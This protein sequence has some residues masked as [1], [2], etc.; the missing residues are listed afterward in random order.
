VNLVFTTLG[1]HPDQAGGAFRYVTELAEGLARRGHLVHAVYP[2]FEQG[3]P[4]VTQELRN[5]VQL[6]RFSV[7][8]AAFFYNWLDRNHAALD[9][10]RIIRRDHP[11]TLLVSCHGYFASAVARSGPPIVSLF[12]GPWA[13]EFLQSKRLT[14]HPFFRRKIIAPILRKVE[15]IALK[16]SRS[17]L[18]ISEYYRRNLKTWH[19]EIS[20]P[21]H[22]IDGGVN[23]DQ[24]RPAPDR[25]KARD[26][27]GLKQSD[28]LFLAVRR[29]E[30]RMGLID[31]IDGFQVIASDFPNARLWIG[32]S[33]SLREALESR[34]RIF[35]LENR[36]RLLGYI[37][38]ADLARYYSAAD[39]VVMPS[40]DL[41][42]F[43]L[44]TVESLACG[45]PVIGTRRGATPEILEPLD[46]NL[47]YDSAS[48]LAAKLRAILSGSITLPSSAL[49]R[50]YVLSRYTWNGPVTA[51][52]RICSNFPGGAE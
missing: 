42:G 15:S 7:H 8:R 16:N 2:S 32:G 27:L 19:P 21:T 46:P 35:G 37:P 43:G 31:L 11:P 5:G 24:F 14:K 45:T 47:L 44:T 28:T 52:E 29:L 40:V 49:C 30:P 41:E 23:T 10:V 1:Y 48:D 26:A 18:T 51:F 3:A 39:C 34:I 20:R 4:R 13:E 33:G 36:A 22:V 6:H 17:I 38:E 50:E 25:V 12:T 9:R